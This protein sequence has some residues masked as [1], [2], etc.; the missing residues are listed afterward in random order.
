MKNKTSYAWVIVAA[1]FILMFSVVGIVINCTSIFLKP[2]SE[3]LGF[4]RTSFSLCVT[5]LTLTLIIGG[6]TVAK[7]LSKVNLRLLMTFCGILTAV[8]YAGYSF[9]TTIPMFYAFSLVIGLGASGV[10]IVPCSVMLTNW[11][12]EKRGFAMGIAFTGSGFGGMVFSQVSNWLIQAYGWSQAY[13]ILSVCMALL[14]LPV[15]LFLVSLSPV[16]KG[17]KAYGASDEPGVETKVTGISAKAYIK[18]KSFLLLSITAFLIGMINLG[19]Q[20]HIPS[21]LTDRG[22]DS[23]FAT[24][25][26]TL[27]MAVLV[28]GKLILGAVFDE[29]G[30]TKGMIYS[31][32]VFVLAMVAMIAAKVPVL[33]ICFAVLFGLCNATATVANPYVTSYIVG[34]REYATIYSVINLFFS[35]GM[36]V[37]TPLSAAIFDSTGTYNPAFGAYAVISLFLIVTVGLA[38]KTGD[39]YNKIIE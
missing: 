5:L 13:L 12:V 4:S 6:M 24:S 25:M 20:S 16:H 35:V 11:F 19:V 17:M 36:A 37:G 1:C 15:T 8:G 22:L 30:P 18:S 39:G 10:T 26:V 29:T 23:T 34:T 9:S 38:V 28:V 32:S 3:S 27:Y 31:S 7:L 33:A 14:I 2:V 21:H